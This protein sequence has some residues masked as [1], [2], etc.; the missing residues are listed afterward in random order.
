MGFGFRFDRH[1]NPGG[2]NPVVE[3]QRFAKLRHP[4]M[5]K[6]PGKSPKNLMQEETWA[7]PILGA[8][9]ATCAID[10]FVLHQEGFEARFFRLSLFW[11]RA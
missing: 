2:K 3:I 9:V 8:G 1:Y 7:T 11:Q 10:F 6:K 4:K 5:A